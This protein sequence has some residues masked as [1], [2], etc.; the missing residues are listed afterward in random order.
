M[1]SNGLPA[2]VETEQ[3]ILGAILLGNHVYDEAEQITS[4]DFS[5]SSHRTIFQCIAAMLEDGRVVELRTLAE[6]LRN[7]HEIDAIGG[8]AYLCSLTE[9]LP[10]QPSIAAYVEIVKEKSRRRALI[11]LCYSTITMVE[12][13]SIDIDELLGT[14]D[15]RLLQISAENSAD[16]ETLPQA[17]QR[18][19]DRI[20]LEHQS[21]G[22]VGL[23]TGIDDLDRRIGGWA[24][25]ELAIIAGKPGQGKS[26]ALMQTL[27]RC[28]KDR[29]PAHL[30]S[31]EMTKGQVLRRL[32]AEVASL[33]FSLLRH[34]QFLSSGD[35]RAL[36]AAKEEVAR[37]PLIIDDDPNLTAAQLASRARISK[38]RY[39]TRLI[40]VD[41]LQKM[42][43]V[44][45]PEHRHLEVSDAA[46][47]L[48]NLAKKER[49]AVV[50]LSSITDKGGRVRDAAPTLGDLRQS[51]DIAYEASTVVIIHR[52][53]D[54]SEHIDEA[55]VMI[56]AKQRGGSTGQFPVHFNDRLMFD[57]GKAEP[58][59][60][61]QYELEG[62]NA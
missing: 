18:E 30:F 36:L 54:E 52:E 51:G 60:R 35:L 59:V 28:G 15:T 29:A 33:R 61:R 44:T 45:K 5:L 27:I 2:S 13:Q 4:D 56:I 37:W 31:P 26:S 19:F 46:V 3:L 41:Y 50:A 40:G 6:E 49:L 7:R 48:A 12:D 14:A 55:G 43:Y 32:W 62:S 21:N 11:T 34:P 42:R 1:Q 25:G 38:R 53:V 10:P 22:L 16:A 57:S 9:Y 58:A 20:L 8:V 39:G 17:S 24:E 23:S 47:K